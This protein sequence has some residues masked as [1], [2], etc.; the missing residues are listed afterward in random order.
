LRAFA[1]VACKQTCLDKPISEAGFN[2]EDPDVN[3]R[4]AKGELVGGGVTGLVERLKSGDVVKSPWLAAPDCRRDM[5]VEA[6]IYERLGAHPRL[7][8]MKHWDPASHVLTLEYMPHGNLKEYV[9]KHGHEISLAQRQQWV[10]EAAEGVE[11]LH[12]HAVIQ[13]DV[14]PHN[15]LLD[16]H[17]SLRICD[18]G[19]SSLDCSQAMVLSGVRYRMPGLERA[20]TV[21]EDLFALGSTIYFIATGHEP[22]EEVV[23]EDEVEKLYAD[24]VFPDL[25]GVMFAE[26]IALCWRQEVDSAKMISRLVMRSSETCQLT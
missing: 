3:I 24:G 6:K 14:G 10:R 2:L 16:A 8:E 15:L 25:S 13:S 12:S 4:E 26:I 20:T 5:A 23:D 7:V 1:H 11:L 21:A 19:G 18:F 9:Q 22:W 17:L